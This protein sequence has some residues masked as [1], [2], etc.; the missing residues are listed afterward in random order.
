LI[1]TGVKKMKINKYFVLSLLLGIALLFSAKA[2]AHTLWLNASDYSPEI[3]P[4]YGARTNI[5]FGWGHRYPVADFLSQDSLNDFTLIQPK[6]KKEKLTPNPGGFLATS[7]SFKEPGTYFVCAKLKP[8]FYTMY[9][10]KGKVHHKVG[11]KTGLKGI[12]LSLYYEE[13]AKALINVGEKS[14]GSFKRKVGHSLEIVPLK[15][16]LELKVGDFLPI[17]VLFKG[18]P[19]RYCKVSATYSGFSSKCDFAFA[20]V[21]NGKGEAKIRI[22]H[23]GPWLVKVSHKLPA[24]DDLKD[25]CNELSYS[26]TL[27]FEIP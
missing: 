21:T 11:P 25:K 14:D 9:E 4:K 1:K 5:Y 19:A 6:G 7:V 15:N 23:Y 18:K 8:G 3:Y 22:I 26:A 12:I 20:T 24:G 16:P 27:T 10:E 2:F 17:Q 13:Y